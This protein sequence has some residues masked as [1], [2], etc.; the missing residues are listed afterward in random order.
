MHGILGAV[1]GAV[2]AAVIIVW[3]LAY[4]HNHDII[5]MGLQAAFGALLSGVLSFA[6]GW[7][8][9]RRSRRRAEREEQELRRIREGGGSGEQ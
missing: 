4:E 7:L 3:A 8:E 5:P 9:H 1:A 2:I 6:G